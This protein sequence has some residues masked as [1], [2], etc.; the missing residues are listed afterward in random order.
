VSLPAARSNFL[1]PGLLLLAACG[2]VAEEK[3]ADSGGERLP[4]SIAADSAGSGPETA[5]TVDTADT[6]LPAEP[7]DWYPDADGD[8]WGADTGKVSAVGA[9]VGF[10]AVGGDCDDQDP[11]VNPGMVERC[12]GIDNDCDP[13]SV[14]FQ[15]VTNGDRVFDEVTAAV[16]AAAA[17][18]TVA[19]CPGIYDGGVIVDVPLT[20]RSSGTADDTV[21]FAGGTMLDARAD[22][23][24]E[25]L[26]IR[27]GSGSSGGGILGGPGV[28]L[29]VRDCVIEENQGWYGCGGIATQSG[30]TLTIEGSTIRDNFT[31][32][33]GVYGGGICADDLA[34]SD[35]A[36]T[37]NYSTYAAGLYAGGTLTVTNTELSD[38][39][40]SWGAAILVGGEA[41]IEGSVLLRNTGGGA[42]A[43]GRRASLASR[44][45]DWGSGPD[46]NECDLMAED[47]SWRRDAPEGDFDCS[48]TGCW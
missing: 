17:G 1:S 28:N 38:N 15:R 27:G 31:A 36:V 29:L 24:I 22:L 13:E 26:G 37:G 41:L 16:E 48:D 35:S 19:V 46:D 23:V 2:G 4:E 43:I 5:G 32:K 18:D 39:E 14:E 30:T 10:V 7:T 12:D 11:N 42:V 45:T 20:L 9:P 6:G 40:G 3:G 21:L 44:S 47:S 33:A 34:I 8:G 25:G